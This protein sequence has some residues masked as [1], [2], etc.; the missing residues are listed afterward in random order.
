ML[1]FILIV[2]VI[3]L[4]VLLARKG[5]GTA[6]KLDYTSI[7]YRQGYWDGVRASEQGA[8]STKNAPE[9][10]ATNVA[11]PAVAS[12]VIHKS[13]ADN[14]VTVNIS[15]YVAS[16]LLVGGIS[17][18][19]R[20][21]MPGSGAAFFWAL[22]TVAAYYGFGFM[23]YRSMPIL[24]PVSI[25][26]V[27]TALAA[28]PYVGYLLH[29]AFIPD[30]NMAW[31]M[32]SIICLLAYFYAAIRL[33]S[34]IIGYALIVVLISTAN[35]FAGVLGAGI[36]WFVVAVM[37]V[38]AA[39]TFVA[40]ANPRWLPQV[41][42]RPFIVTQHVIVPLAV[43]W[44][45]MLWS[46]LGAM[47]YAVTFAVATLYYGAAALQSTQASMR[48]TWLWALARGTITVAIGC[49]VYLV[50]DQMYM[51]G[52]AMAVV[53][54]LQVVLSVLNLPVGR[55]IV[56][57]HEVWAWGGFG[58]MV[59]GSWMIGG[60]GWAERMVIILASLLVVAAVVAWYLR[61]SSF[62]GFLVYAATLLPYIIC[63]H[64]LDATP[65]WVSV[66][67]YMVLLLSVPLGRWR[68]ARRNTQPVELGLVYAAQA[69]FSVML[70]CV[71]GAA[72][73][74]V[75]HHW[76]AL[77]WVVVALVAYLMVYLGKRVW[78]LIVAN[79]LA[80]IALFTVAYA[81]HLTGMRS[82][83]FVTAIGFVGFFAAYMVL[84]LRNRGTTLHFTLW[85]S[86]II[87]ALLFSI[88]GMFDGSKA[89][90]YAFGLLLVVAGA[91]MAYDDYENRRLRF[92]DI[93]FVAV[94]LGLQRML[95]VTAPEISSLLY[96]HWWAALGFTLAYMHA[97][98]GVSSQSAGVT[99]LYKVVGLIVITLY[100]LI[101]TGAHGA[102]SWA[103]AV[104]LAEHALIVVYGLVRNSRLFTIWGAVGVTLAILIMLPALA[105]IMLPLLGV[106]IIAAVVYVIA[107]NNRTT[108]PKD[109]A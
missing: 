72:D 104:F 21:F 107:K 55:R 70:V 32:T 58:L 50:T 28:M 64:L 82:L 9:Q 10:I 99:R 6:E 17:L 22:A 13:P 44:A 20:L 49:L 18:F 45:L 90:A 105:F 73:Q 69:A 83:F 47:E 41:F 24:K 62:L 86:A 76:V 3:I 46:E 79:A 40:A 71:G 109:T 12:A 89:L 7:S 16:L 94:T 74:S 34:E 66:V 30:A 19:V 38:G 57:Q 23:L 65:A 8:S 85:L 81:L 1:S 68:V 54:A 102:E 101:Y 15:L 59:F 100:G 51:V 106:G 56:N 36:L 5:Q 37:A 27:G 80:I 11:V 95:Y 39:I 25:A 77:S 103:K 91:V 33:Q 93:G 92:A 75:Q 52:I 42:K 78:A 63:Y 61:R 67:A 48:R 96:S 108:P 84:R 29:Q 43:A 97:K 31:L 26:F 4:S 14:H 60:D 35:S 98:Y 87:V 88:I 53:G 2:A